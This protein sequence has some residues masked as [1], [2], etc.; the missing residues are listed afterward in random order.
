MHARSVTAVSKP[1][2]LLGL[3][4][5]FANTGYAVVR[6][7]PT[8]KVEAAGVLVTKKSDKKKKILSTDDNFSRA[9][10]ISLFLSNLLDTWDI[11]LVCA[12]S[13]SFPPS[14]S[15]A[16]KMA[17]C[18]GVVA[19][20]AQ[21]RG[22]PVFQASP[23]EVKVAVHG[24]KSASKEEVEASVIKKG[25]DISDLL[26]GT[27]RSLHEH[28]YDATA[29]VLTAQDSDLVRILRSNRA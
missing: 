20:L 22:I 26:K 7:A 28:A 12:E 3:D 17:M 21:T 16:A 23:Q 19:C 4:P 10:A 29:V 25:F 5:G 27:A 18:W 11:A 15:A 24:S 2:Y 6:I 8:S 1:L 14:A 13:M 9:K